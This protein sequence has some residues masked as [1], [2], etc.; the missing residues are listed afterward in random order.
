MAGLS[1]PDPKS[2][3]SPVRRRWRPWAILL[4]II[5]FAGLAAGGYYYY[6]MR[7]DAVPPAAGAAA[8]PTGG[9]P[10]AGGPG[11]PGAAGPARPTPVVATRAQTAD[12]QIWLKAIGSVA[13]ANTVTVR[14]RVD[15][16]LMRVLFSEGQVVKAGDLLAEI[17]PRPYQAQLE[18]A[19]GQLAR[20]SALLDNARIDLQRYRTL[21]KQDSIAKQQ[22]DT[23]EALVR[24]Y[25]GT[26]KVDKGQVDNAKLQLSY[27]RITAPITG[28]IGLRAV[29]AGNIVKAGD[30]NGLA[31]ITQVTPISV[32]FT[33]PEDSLP[34]VT[35]RM[36]E[37]TEVPVQAFD[38]SQANKLASGRLVTI[39]NQIDATT[40]TV[41]LK[42]EFP[43]DDG[44]LFPNQFVNIRLLLD[45][46]RGATVIPT[47]AIQRAGQN[48]F[49]YAITP[50]SRIAVRQVTLGPLEGN[51]TIIET[52]LQP[53]DQVVTDGGDRLREGTPVTVAAPP[54]EAPA[55]AAGEQLANP[56]RPRRAPDGQGPPPGNQQQPQRPRQNQAGSGNS[57]G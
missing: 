27:A 11:G 32:I 20:D 54:G 17:D 42:A 34:A 7:T 48:A 6:R 56:Q 38:R 9:P 44:A 35:R 18:Q 2:G 40:G 51:R 33:I 13:A 41:K 49:V 15:G 45:V 12:M 43:N 53:G 3:P 46:R 21:F 28:R 10:R 52:G 50:E 23:Q 4:W 39:D 25:E 5:C 14:S 31:T 30:T 55:A 57:G 26:V 47:A 8:P 1:D 37:G 36:R 22:V 19:E 24:Q 29:D 16:Q